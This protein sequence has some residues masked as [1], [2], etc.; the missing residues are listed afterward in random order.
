MQDLI[1]I[2]LDNESKLT[3]I[4]VSGNIDLN[5]ISKLSDSLQEKRAEEPLLNKD[6]DREN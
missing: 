5:S 2:A 4:T 1:L 6:N 3:I